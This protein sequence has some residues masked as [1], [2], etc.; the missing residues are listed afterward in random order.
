MKEKNNLQFLTPYKSEER[1]YSDPDWVLADWNEFLFKHKEG[2]FEN[3]LNFDSFNRYPNTNDIDLIKKIAQYSNVDE[4]NLLLY[5]GSDEALLNIFDTF[6]DQNSKVL[7]FSPTYSQVKPFILKN[8]K[9]LLISNI[10]SPYDGHFYN[11]KDI[12]KADVVYIVNPNNPT[13]KLI[14]KTVL[15]DL[16]NK[17]SDKLFI[18]DE[19]YYE[20]SGV[21]LSKEVNKN[22]NLIVTR[23]FSKAFGLAG[24]RIGYLITSFDNIA[25]LLKIKNIKSPNSLAIQAAKLV[26]ENID[27]YLSCIEI[28]EQSKQ[29]IYTTLSELELRYIESKSNFILFEYKHSEELF[30]YFKTQ[31][32]L[33]RNRTNYENLT[34]SIR[35]TIGDNLHTQ[36]FIS[37]LKKFEF[38]S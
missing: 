12:E 29:K 18:I 24:L 7:L 30:N 14:E 4:Q 2:I 8:T 5:S 25:S 23:T 6:V 21:S 32:Y 28:V 20:F 13:G 3:L 9:N 26:M 37:I 31:K 35:V 38:K 10:Q 1:N 15:L 16:I 33:L 17:Y 34:N 22:Q 27:Y 36:N 19:A 11:F